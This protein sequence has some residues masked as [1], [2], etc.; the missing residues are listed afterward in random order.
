[1]TRSQL[2]SWQRR[3]DCTLADPRPCPEAL[4]LLFGE[5][6]AAFVE[7]EGALRRWMRRAAVLE[8][9]LRLTERF[10][11]RNVAREQR[12]VRQL[13]HYEDQL[14]DSTLTALP[15]EGLSALLGR[16]K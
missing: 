14:T 13:A 12:D 8:R 9:N 7:A 15:A 16:A 1:M 4:H 2:A 3:L 11:A 6:A 10:L 5:M